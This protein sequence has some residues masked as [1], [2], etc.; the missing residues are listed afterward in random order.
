ML[1]YSIWII[2]FLSVFIVRYAMKKYTYRWFGKD[3]SGF[4]INI[5]AL[6]V[7][8]MLAG[9]LIIVPLIIISSLFS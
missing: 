6:I 3:A 7:G 2:L 5:S 1:D 4:E 8:P 9:T